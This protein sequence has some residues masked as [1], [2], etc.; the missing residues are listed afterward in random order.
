MQGYKV[1]KLKAFLLNSLVANISSLTQQTILHRA[2]E[3]QLN[4]QGVRQ[5]RSYLN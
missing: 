5:L 1:K 2:E 3:E 4:S